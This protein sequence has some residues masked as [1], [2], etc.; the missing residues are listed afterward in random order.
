M[1]FAKPS[2]VRRSLDMTPMIGIVFLV[3]IFLL[4]T[5]TFSLSRQDESIRLPWSE[6]AR[7]P[8]TRLE[9]PVT[10]QLTRDGT[11]LLGG[12]EVAF[13]ALPS[14]LET[15]RNALE[16]QGRKPS[17]ATVV[18]RADRDVPTGRV[19]EVVELGQRVGFERFVF[20]AQEPA[21]TSPKKAKP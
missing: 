7:P 13:G 18:L 10:L 6:L 21:A 12:R 8:A 16:A 5:L 17:Q 20:R 9:S 11:V 19:Q 2:Q 4:V 3:V 1:Q 15:E 14:L